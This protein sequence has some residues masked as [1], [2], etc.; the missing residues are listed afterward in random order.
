MSITTVFQVRRHRKDRLPRGAGR[1]GGRRVLARGALLLAALGVLT[2][3]CSIRKL[4]MTQ[5]G[6]A[7]AGGGQTFASD[8]DPELVR[9]AAPFSLKLMESVLA[10]VPQHIRLH[11]AAASGFT[12]YA[13]AFVQQEADELENEDLARTTALR[14]RAKRLYLRARDHGLSGLESAHPGFRRRLAQNPRVA[15]QSARRADVPLLYW[16]AV[17]WAAAISLA[18]D[19]PALVG[20]IPQMEALIDRA[21]ELDECYGA[22]AIHTFLITYEMA[23]QGAPGDAAARARQHFERAIALAG[24][25]QV[26]PWVALAEAVCVPQQDWKQFEAL[27]HRALEVDAD[28]HPE[29]RLVNLVMQRRAR[30]LLSKRDELFLLSDPPQEK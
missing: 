11:S 5:L 29:F 16:T 22:G 28:A 12:Q 18:K 17:S 10:E 15:A 19:E 14:A 2:T 27:L 20:E 3:G 21:L 9:A 7:L 24:G 25:R 23:R 26:A 8:D 1:G 6:H 30:W 13:Y 4:A